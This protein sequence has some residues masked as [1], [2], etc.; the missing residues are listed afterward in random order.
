MKG[1]NNHLLY[2]HGQPEG[3]TI[4]GLVLQIGSGVRGRVRTVRVDGVC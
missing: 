1:R 4:K 2:G 3:R